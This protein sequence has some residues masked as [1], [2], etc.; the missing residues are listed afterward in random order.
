MDR[1]CEACARK[2]ARSRPT[3]LSR[4]EPCAS[5]IAEAL[6]RML[7]KT[8]NKKQKQVVFRL[9]FL[10]KIGEQHPQL[11][12]LQLS[13][14]LL[15]YHFPAR[16]HAREVDWRLFSSTEVRERSNFPAILSLLVR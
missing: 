11:D 9:I 8:K 5:T 13:L 4:L 1:Y 12:R 3:R 2:D 10:F 7:Q 15:V 16:L 6:A 14:L